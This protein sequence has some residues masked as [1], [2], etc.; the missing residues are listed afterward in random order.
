MSSGSVWDAVA[1][2]RPS[3]GRA[4][5]LFANRSVPATWTETGNKQI[6]CDTGPRDLTAFACNPSVAGW[7]LQPIVAMKQSDMFLNS[8][9]AIE[10]H[11]RSLANTDWSAHTHKKPGPLLSTRFDQLHDSPRISNFNPVL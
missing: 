6:T 7:L 3:V 4:Q 2:S 5:G 8:L 1:S 9:A 11:L 10:K